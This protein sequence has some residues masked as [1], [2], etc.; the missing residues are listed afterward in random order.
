MSD[1][2][3]VSFVT[4]TSWEVKLLMKVSSKPRSTTKGISLIYSKKIKLIFK[5]IVKKKKC[6]TIRSR[7]KFHEMGKLLYH[8]F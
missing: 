8:F 1:I 7:K 6:L 2:F 5:L 4:T 3:S